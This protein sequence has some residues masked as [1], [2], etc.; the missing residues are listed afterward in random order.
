MRTG[1][2]SVSGC[3][4]AQSEMEHE[5]IGRGIDGEK[6]RG[7]KENVRVTEKKVEGVTE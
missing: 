5:F 1:R 6:P 7:E 3:T 2:V 4:R